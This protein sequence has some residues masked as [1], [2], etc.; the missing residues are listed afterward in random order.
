MSLV[1]IVESIQ[2]DVKNL[3]GVTNDMDTGVGVQSTEQTKM[4][5]VVR[6]SKFWR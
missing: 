3:V 4:D 5:L 2:D 1:S 6:N